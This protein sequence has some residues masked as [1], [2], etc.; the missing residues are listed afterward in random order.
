ML[1]RCHTQVHLG[2]RKLLM[3]AVNRNAEFRSRCA[4]GAWREDARTM[5]VQREGVATI[6]Q[7]VATGK[8]QA[9]FDQ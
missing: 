1:R 3:E 7:R 2:L 4:F 8:L 6:Q 5:R 9:A